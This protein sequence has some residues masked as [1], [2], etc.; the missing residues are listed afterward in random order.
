[1]NEKILNLTDIK[2]VTS[3]IEFLLIKQNIVY[4]PDNQIKGIEILMEQNDSQRNK[5][6]SN[7]SFVIKNFENYLYHQ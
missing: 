7:F 6:I 5:K 2:F 1:M 4:N 3:F